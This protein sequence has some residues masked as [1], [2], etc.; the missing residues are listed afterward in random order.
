MTSVS[1]S[2]ARTCWLFL[3][4]IFHPISVTTFHF[5]ISDDVAIRLSKSVYNILWKLLPFPLG[6]LIQL[7][8]TSF[9]VNYVENIVYILRFDALSLKFVWREVWQTLLAI[10]TDDTFGKESY[11]LQE[12]RTLQYLHEHVFV[13]FLSPLSLCTS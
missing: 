8:C 7:P 4:I 2:V 3:T 1:H 12:C 13:S 9:F 11:H 5:S 6:W 10:K